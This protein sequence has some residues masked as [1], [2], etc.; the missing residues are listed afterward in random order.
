MDK[1]KK[2]IASGGVYVI[3]EAGSCHDGSRTRALLLIEAAAEAGADAVKFQYW[4]SAKRMAQRRNAAEYEATYARYAV[5][6]SWLAALA[7]HAASHDVDFMCSTYLPEDVDVVAPFVDT[8]KVASFESGDP[9]HLAA[10]GAH[11][12]N[13]KNVV[14]SLGLGH[15]AE[16]V[17]HYVAPQRH[18]GW[19][20]SPEGRGL[21]ALLHCV[22]AYPAHPNT[23]GLVGLRDRVG[24][25]G[26]SD[27]TEG[28]ETR[29]GAVA[30]AC[31]ARVIERH[32]RLATTERQNPDFEHAATTRQL[33]DYIEGVRF[34]TMALGDNTGRET[35]LNAR[36]AEEPMARYA[37]GKGGR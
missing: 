28:S 10:H 14:V 23:L 36:R 12:D 31:G 37:V 17:R 19:K 15:S 24:L 20:H 4:S 1:F 35:W 32:F 34:A 3:A 6:S 22:S 5:P 7:R 25:V 26:F 21:L 11:L 9:V 13:G 16:V 27:H 8:F 29:T 2:T 30:A 18:M 33:A